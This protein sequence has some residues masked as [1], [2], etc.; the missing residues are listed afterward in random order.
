[1]DELRASLRTVCVTGTNGKTST[2]RLI[3][4]IVEAAGGVSAHVTTLGAVVAGQ[5][6]DYDGSMKAFSAV[7]AA[8]ADAGATILAV[9]TTSRALESGFATRWPPDVAVFTNLSRDHLDRH[10]SPE[11]YLAA[12]ARLFFA[13]PEMGRAILN[14]NDPACVLLAENL[15]ETIDVRG[16]AT[17]EADS[18]IAV[19]LRAAQTEAHRD[20]ARVVLAPSPFADALGGELTLA[21]PGAFQVDN[22]LAAALAARALDLPDAA[23]REGI[24]RFGGV[25]GRFQRVASRPLVLVDYAHTPDALERTLEAARALVE[26]PGALVCVFGC[27]GERDHGKRAEM[28]ALADVL[29]DRVLL[30]TDNARSEDPEAIA[31][32]IRAGAVGRSTWDEERDRRTAIERAVREASPEDVVVIAGRGH[33]EVQHLPTGSVRLSD[34]DVA[35][36]VAGRLGL[37]I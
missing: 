23:I 13:L 25:P 1:M 3:A 5:T 32:M 14:A 28:G 35:R 22:A 18:P 19:A 17:R 36:R 4:S 29:A 2:T 24:A 26:S 7:A 27:G 30:T 31:E 21:V 33:E 37:L 20:G 9:E 34:A 11:A 6:L 10:G 16:F 8:A 15:P 12:K